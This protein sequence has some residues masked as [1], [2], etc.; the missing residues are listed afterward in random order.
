MRN[1]LQTNTVPYDPAV[2]NR[3]GLMADPPG[4]LFRAGGGY[5][6]PWTRDASV[7]AWNAGSLLAPDVS[8]NTLWSVV[9][10]RLDGSLIVQQ[11]NQWWDQAIWAI[12]ALS[13]YAVTGDRVF[14][15]DA[16]QTVCNTLA[17]LQHTRF[18]TDDGLFRGPAV[19]QDGISGYPSPP[20]Q[21]DNPS[22]FVLDHPGT[23]QIMCLSTNCLYVGAYT[24]AADMAHYLGRPQ[25]ESTAH[26]A[27]ARAVARAVNAR[28]WIPEQKRYGYFLHGSGPFR[29]HLDTHEE[30]C[31][32]AFAILFRVADHQRMAL[33]LASHHRQPCGTVNVWPHFGRFSD[34]KPGRHE[35][36]VWPMVQ[37]M[38][39][40]AATMGGRTDLFSQE[41]ASLAGLARA[42]GGFFEVYDSVSGRE[43]GGWQAGVHGV[44]EPDQTW[45][46]TSY[47]RMVHHGLFGMRLAPNRL[48]FVPT[49]PASWG[50]VRLT[51]LRYRGTTLTVTLTGQG[52][53]I[54]S[55]HLDGHSL[56]CPTI[57]ADLTGHHS[58]TIEL[59]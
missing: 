29:G 14:L 2:H 26:S 45:S 48:E 42:S 44:S 12:G 27:A 37:G 9:E 5:G 10:R 22:P 59:A 38:W 41:M 58:L 31:G 43:D 56:P 25:S 28:L 49:L 16:Y 18:S 57:P 51:G 4:T 11:D 23:E 34:T 50:S 19:M 54:Q 24:A 35:V 8:R 39:A 17:H 40:H 33:L 21:P 7:N 52:S 13:H 6:Q 46:A 32:A 55:T 53:R 15:H 30:S 36:M 20:C 3:T 47:L 1:L